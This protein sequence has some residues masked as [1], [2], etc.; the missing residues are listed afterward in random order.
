MAIQEMM[1]VGLYLSGLQKVTFKFT[2]FD[3]NLEETQNYAK[4]SIYSLFYCR[5]QTKDINQWM[6]RF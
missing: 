6:Y 3:S 4:C 1:E 5:D 2:Y